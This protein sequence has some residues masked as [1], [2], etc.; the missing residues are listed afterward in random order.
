MPELALRTPM[1]C[2]RAPPGALRLCHA[3]VAPLGAVV[4]RGAAMASIHPQNRACRASHSAQHIRVAGGAVA[5]RRFEHQEPVSRY[6][7]TWALLRAHWRSSPLHRARTEHST[8]LPPAPASAR[9]TLIISIRSSRR[10]SDTFAGFFT[11]RQAGRAQSSVGVF[12][13]Q[14]SMVPVPVPW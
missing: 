10:S 6:I 12:T 8:T 14:P 7:A 9:V 13:Q 1:R 11:L 4:G 5:K 2:K 3:N